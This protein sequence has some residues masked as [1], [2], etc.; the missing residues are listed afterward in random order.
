M[1]GALAVRARL[2]RGPSPRQRPR[3]RRNRTSIIAEVA[4]NT[5]V[6]APLSPIHAKNHT[7]LLRC[8]SPI[9]VDMRARVRCLTRLSRGALKTRLRL[10]RAA[11][12]EKGTRSRTSSH[13]SKSALK[14]R[15]RYAHDGDTGARK[16]KYVV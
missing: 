10:S 15:L 6:L 12:E 8:L 11:P 1:G 4:Q 2:W 3:L 13:T 9:S 16:I 7:S 14:T 5:R